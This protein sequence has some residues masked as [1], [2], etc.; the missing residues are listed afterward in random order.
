MAADTKHFEILCITFVQESVP[1]AS[2]QYGTDAKRLLARLLPV[3]IEGPEATDLR[4][5][6]VALAVL[7]Q[8]LKDTGNHL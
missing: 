5:S 6:N 2:L 1:M 3:V 4:V 8:A 7:I